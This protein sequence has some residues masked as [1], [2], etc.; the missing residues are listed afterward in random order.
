VIRVLCAI[1]RSRIK[2][3]TRGDA[4]SDDADETPTPHPA[5]AAS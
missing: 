1:Y 2:Y 5:T 4:D 3:P